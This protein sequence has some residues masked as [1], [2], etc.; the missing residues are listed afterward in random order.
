MNIQ[1][2]N[3]FDFEDDVDRDEQVHFLFGQLLHKDS[4]GET[5]VVGRHLEVLEGFLVGPFVEQTTHQQ[6][7]YPI[8]L[9]KWS[10]I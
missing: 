10:S 5:V 1:R 7:Y 6:N 2:L 3:A 9:D 8:Y 4:V